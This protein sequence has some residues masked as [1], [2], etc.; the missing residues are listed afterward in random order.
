MTRQRVR[1]RF[2][3]QDDLRWISHRDLMR[4][5]ERLFRRAGVALSMTEGFH[6]KPRIN[7]PSALAVGIA[8]LDELLEVDLA[9]EHTAQSLQT[10][11]GPQ[12][13][14]GM[15]V[16]A[17]HVLPAPD[18]KA[19]V[20]YVTFEIGIPREREPALADRI[21]W[22]LNQSSFPIE[23]EGRKSPLDL[24]PLITELALRRADEQDGVLQMRLRVDR[25]GSARPREVLQALDIEDL[26]Y[27]GFFLTRTCVEVE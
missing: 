19:Q 20:K 23:R 8:G 25:E 17:I 24:R 7:F 2:S 22:L 18:H 3:K 14:P 10:V 12:L 4:V 15:N 16:G 27:E 6:P 26:E 21:D 5:W 11:I 13:P 9:E 1:I